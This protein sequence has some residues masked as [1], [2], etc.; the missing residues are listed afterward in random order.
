ML[1][2]GGHAVVAVPTAPHSIGVPAVEAR[3][4]RQPKEWRSYSHLSTSSPL[5]ANVP[6]HCMQL[7]RSHARIDSVVVPPL[8]ST[9][10]ESGSGQRTR[11]RQFLTSKIGQHEGRTIMGLSVSARTAFMGAVVT[12]ACVQPFAYVNAQ[13]SVERTHSL[14]AEPNRAAS[15]PPNGYL[16]A[17]NHSR[18]NLAVGVLVVLDNGSRKLG[19]TAKK[20]GQPV[21]DSLSARGVAARYFYMDAPEGGRSHISI[22]V[23]ERKYASASGATMFTLSNIRSELNAIRDSHNSLPKRTI[24]VPPE[25]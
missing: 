5:L 4:R 17:T 15:T 21:V 25:R 10:I 1:A 22:F 16:A 2:T 14:S 9:E 12:V 19:W 7:D 3:V 24:M 8:L 6:V 11:Q 20:A 13:S 18:G 23:N